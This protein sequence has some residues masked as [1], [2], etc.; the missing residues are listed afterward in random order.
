MIPLSIYIAVLVHVQRIFS[1]HLSMSG[2]SECTCAAIAVVLHVLCYCLQS[3]LYHTTCLSPLFFYKIA[4]FSARQNFYVYC[5]YIILDQVKY[6]STSK[7]NQGVGV[8]ETSPTPCNIVILI[9]CSVYQLKLS[10]LSTYILLIS[11]SLSLSLG[12]LVNITIF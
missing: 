3:M 5:I 10:L 9:V 1:P 6:I 7:A 11:L 4:K 2:C 12:V 8:S